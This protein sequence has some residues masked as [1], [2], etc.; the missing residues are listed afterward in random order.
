MEAR[1]SE[2][3]GTDLWPGFD[4]L[5]VPLAIHDG[6]H[7][8]LF[9]HPAPPPGFLPVAGAHR[10]EGRHPAVATTTTAE[11]GGVETAIVVISATQVSIEVVASMA[12][13][14]AFVS[15]QAERH[16]TWTDHGSELLVYA[17]ADTDLIGLR[18]LEWEALHRALAAKNETTAA[19]W[20]G[21]AIEL[22]DERFKRMPPGAVAT[23]RVTEK[24]HGLARY[25]ERR[26]M[27]SPASLA[28]FRDLA[29]EGAGPRGDLVGLA[30]AQLLDRFAPGWRHAMEINDS[31][32]LDRHLAVA[33]PSPRGADSCRSATRAPLPLAHTTARRIVPPALRR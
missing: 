2:L 13:H 16:P 21:L 29:P 10:S 19:C 22:R 18:L 28:S 9:R 26:A 1:V 8:W 25:V 33:L 27:P 6:S 23:E 12:I 20:A 32:D 17:V 4:P 31:M 3:A 14:Q 7:T 24:R 11:I 5:A 15:F 30:L